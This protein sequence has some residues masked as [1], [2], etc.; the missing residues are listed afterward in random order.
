MAIRL[1]GIGIDRRASYDHAADWRSYSR[2][3]Q[4]ERSQCAASVGWAVANVKPSSLRRQF[5][6]CRII[7]HIKSHI[8]RVYRQAA[9]KRKAARVVGCRLQSDRVNERD[10]LG[11]T[12]KKIHAVGRRINLIAYY[13]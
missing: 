4:S 5:S 8:G 7:G 2:C 6:R 11:I 10:I 3:K 9:Q 1:V 12:D 13:K